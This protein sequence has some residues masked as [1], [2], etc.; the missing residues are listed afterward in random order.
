MNFNFAK[1]TLIRDIT[2]KVH[3]PHKIW[4]CVSREIMESTSLSRSAVKFVDDFGS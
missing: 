2:C 4:K 1:L 3:H